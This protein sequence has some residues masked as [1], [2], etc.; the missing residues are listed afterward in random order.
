MPVQ[1]TYIHEDYWTKDNNICEILTNRPQPPRN[2]SFFVMWN[3]EETDEKKLEMEIHQLFPSIPVKKLNTCKIQLVDFYP[4][5]LINNRKYLPV[6]KIL[7][8]IVPIPPMIKILFSMEIMKKKDRTQITKYYSDSIKVWALLIKFTIEILSR[9]NFV[10]S[11]QQ[12]DENQ[13]E[14]QWVLLL[15]NYKDHTRLNELVKNAA[16]ASYNLAIDFILIEDEMYDFSQVTTGLWHPSYL[17][18]DFINKTGDFLIRSF[19]QNGFYKKFLHIY[20]AQDNLNENFCVMDENSPWDLRFLDCAIGKNKDFNIERFCDTPI[21]NILRNWV[22]NAQG[23][24]YYL[25][26]DMNFRLEYPETPDADWNLGFYIQPHQNQSN[27]IPLAD[28]W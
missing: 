19:L 28:V 15:K 2:S 26:V 22:Q 12:K 5:V 7:A 18:T 10:P 23:F 27:C 16:W 13:Y 24:P 3:R 14:S 17:F 21:P 25:G 11:L 9:G 8:K 20:Q 1:L 6:R 4:A